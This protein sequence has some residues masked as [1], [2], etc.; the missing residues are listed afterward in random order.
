MTELVA[1]PPATTAEPRLNGSMGGA[2][3]M[4]I[5]LAFAAPITSVT[6]IIPLAIM[7]GGAGATAA[8]LV[9]TVLILIFS[10]GFV[11]MTREVD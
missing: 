9:S 6:S 2:S 10:V 5:V 8:V 11:A 3:L 7:F 1:K 4:L